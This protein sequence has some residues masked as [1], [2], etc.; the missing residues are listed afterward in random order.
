MKIAYNVISV[1]QFPTGPN[2]FYNYQSKDNVN[3]VQNKHRIE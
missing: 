3:I 2:S 1:M